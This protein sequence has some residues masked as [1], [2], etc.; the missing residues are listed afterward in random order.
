MSHSFYPSWLLNFSEM[1]RIEDCITDFSSCLLY[2]T[3]P[4]QRDFYLMFC[5][6]KCSQYQRGRLE[7]NRA[8]QC[9]LPL[10][11]CFKQN[12]RCW[13]HLIIKPEYTTCISRSFHPMGWKIT[14]VLGT[15]TSNKSFE[16]CVVLR[17]LFAWT[18][19]VP[20]VSCHRKCPTGSGGRWER[21]QEKIIFMWQNSQVA[22]SW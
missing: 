6:R 13:F 14:I 11:R 21:Q 8:S 3:F 4:R 16:T 20:L 5:L 9:L 10:S 17:I 7:K 1:T 22:Y 12:P 2:K 15:C 18:M 19:F